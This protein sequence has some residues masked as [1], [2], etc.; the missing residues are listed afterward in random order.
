MNGRDHTMPRP[1]GQLSP[2]ADETKTELATPVGL[3]D[4]EAQ[5]RLTA[6]G[7]NELPTAK[8]RGIL[9]IAVEVAREPMFVLLVAAGSV[10]LVMGQLADALMLL[11]FVFVVMGI[12]IVQERRTERALGALRDL[13]SPRALVVRGGRQLRIAGREVVRGDVVLVAEGDRIPADAILRR[14][15][16]LS[17][18]ESLLTGES[19]PVRKRASVA[20]QELQ[21]P[22]GD[23]L[24][25]LFAGT[26]V[27]S[28]QGTA[29]VLA[30]GIRNELGRI[31]KALQRIEPEATPLQRETGR[32]VRTLA[33]VGLAACA[34]VVVAYAF[35]RG[36]DWQ[37][38]KEG[39]LAGIAMAMAILPA[40]DK[41]DLSLLKQAAGASKTRLAREDEFKDKFPGCELG[42]MPPFGNLYG[43]EVFAAEALAADEEIVFSAGSHTEL[44]RMAYKD[45][46]H[47]V[48][49]RIVKLTPAG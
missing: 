46:E 18:D 35:T 12:T 25:S 45:F 34:V 9:A 8:P 19:V 48:Q 23:D 30:T 27:T 26:L 28:G 41:V 17:V 32:I 22:G 44:I 39:L 24:P 40:S 13:S 3:S 43:M 1:A 6:D 4:S 42:A 29:E 21:R 2:C 15:M 47:L 36:G 37:V 14:G 33:V 38:W 7:P 31:G 20:A 49:P 10:Y 11:G 5:E 16:N